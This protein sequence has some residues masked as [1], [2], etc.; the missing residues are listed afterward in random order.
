MNKRL[1]CAGHSKHVFLSKGIISFLLGFSKMVLASYR[2]T[3]RRGHYFK[4]INLKS[5]GTTDLKQT[6]QSFPPRCCLMV[7]DG[8]SCYLMQ[9]LSAIVHEGVYSESSLNEQDPT[10]FFLSFALS[11]CIETCPRGNSYSDCFLG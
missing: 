1:T 4:Q 3:F 9:L 2:L 7:Q 5:A 6:K 11:S 8:L 10:F